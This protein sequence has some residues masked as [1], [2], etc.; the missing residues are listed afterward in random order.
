MMLAVSE[1]SAPRRRPM[2]ASRISRRPLSREIAAFL[3][4]SWLL[5]AMTSDEWC[6]AQEEAAAPP[7]D[8][9]G[10]DEAAQPEAADAA[11]V[12]KHTEFF[13]CIL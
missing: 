1:Q 12:T 11:E 6:F 8:A 7:A 13:W 10:A 4:L 5:H 9:A 2:R 3:V